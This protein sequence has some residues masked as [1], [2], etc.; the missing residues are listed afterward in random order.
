MV[1]DWTLYTGLKFGEQL[2]L[3][4]GVVGKDWSPP[5]PKRLSL[6]GFIARECEKN[7]T[8]A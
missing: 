7:A 6:L 5:E 8:S 3:L 4:A 2:S 1:E